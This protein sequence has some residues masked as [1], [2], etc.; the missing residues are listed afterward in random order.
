MFFED[1][2]EPSTTSKQKLPPL[3]IVG[4]FNGTDEE[5]KQ[6]TIAICSPNF[7]NAKTFCEQV[8]ALCS[9][10]RNGTFKVSYRKI[11][12]V[13][14]KDKS[15]IRDQ[16][17]NFLRGDV[18]DGRPPMLHE[19]ELEQIYNEIIR[20]HSNASYPIYPSYKDVDTFIQSKFG[21]ILL[22]DTLRHIFRDKFQDYFKSCL[23]KPME[24]KRLYASIND[25]EQNLNNLGQII[26]GI[27]IEFVFNCDEMGEQ[28]WAD[29]QTQT[30]IVPIGFPYE[31]APYPVVLEDMHL[32]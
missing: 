32:H 12:E 15:S 9:Y 22:P 1:N 8:G 11:G 18:P 13:F 24:D 26:R 10:L 6:F 29:A 19:S 5:F 23:G 3:E 31:Y 4:P 21:I 20:L 7:K 17:M 14:H 16:H 30:L 27:P 25:I 2:Q 28:T